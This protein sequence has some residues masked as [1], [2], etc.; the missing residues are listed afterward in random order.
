MN[1][2]FRWTPITLKYQRQKEKGGGGLLARA[3][4]HRVFLESGL[5][6]RCNVFFV[7]TWTHLHSLSCSSKLDAC[8]FSLPCTQGVSWQLSRRHF[9][10]VVTRL[11]WAG[12]FYKNSTLWDVR[13]WRHCV[14]RAS[15]TWWRPSWGWTWRRTTGRAPSPPGRWRRDK[16]VRCSCP[17]SGS[18]RTRSARTGSATGR[19]PEQ[20]L[21]TRTGLSGLPR[22]RPIEEAHTLL[23]LLTW[24][25]SIEKIRHQWVNWVLFTL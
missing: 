9:I 5:V 22:C 10:Q 19:W 8:N 15:A 7:T 17:G 20:R 12:A 3:V 18:W 24:V 1:C 21:R 23:L 16:S 25:D 13:S 11:L 4:R 14:S 2:K 6:F